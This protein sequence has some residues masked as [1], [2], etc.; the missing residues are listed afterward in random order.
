MSQIQLIFPFLGK[1]FF[2]KIIIII[3][4]LGLITNGNLV[5]NVK[6]S[7]KTTTG[8]TL[9]FLIIWILLSV[10]FGVYPG[11]S[12]A[13]LLQNY[14]KMLIMFFL[15][16]G[17]IT[18]KDDINKLIWVY[19]CAVGLLSASTVMTS[20]D[21]RMAISSDIYDANDTA[22]QFLLAFPFILWKLKASK[23]L[24]R[25]ALLAIGFIILVGMVKTGSRGGFL[26]LVVII[27]LFVLQLKKLENTSLI[28]GFFLIS[29]VSGVI[30]YN[31]ND[32]YIE[33]ISTLFNIS[34]DYNLTSSTGRI[35]IWKRGI[36]M[37][38]NNPM[39][40]VGVI[41]FISAEGMFYIDTGSR[42]NAAHNSF[43]QIGSE[44]GFPGLI[45]FCLLIYY[46]VKN[47]RKIAYD[48]TKISEDL[49]WRY[50]A[51]SIVGSWIGFVVSGSLLSAA[52]TSF[53]YFLLALSLVFIRIES[54]S[55]NELVD[56]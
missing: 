15:V 7:M 34:D 46:S 31:S 52:Y 16:L 17:Y 41:N 33:R 26:G 28:K 22:L 50:T 4:I 1:I 43:I 37:M 18:S 11:Q 27:M 51:L 19:I 10:P 23:G 30:I 40:G 44:L 14:W 6:A 55:S 54:L 42:W 2:Q 39:L 20:G 12:V 35:E 49:F 13:F 3:A 32:A 29:I 47:I 36:D 21:S 48:N 25:I 24:R 56:N 45:A 9:S 8:R 5:D 53:F 38:V